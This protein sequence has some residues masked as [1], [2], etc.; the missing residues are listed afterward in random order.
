TTRSENDH[1]RNAP[2]H[3]DEGAAFGSRAERQVKTDEA[4]DRAAP[5]AVPSPARE[6]NDTECGERSTFVA[7]H[8][9]DRVTR[10]KRSIRGRRYRQP[11]RL[12]PKHGNVGG[13]VPTGEG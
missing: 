1:S 4:V 2:L 5:D 6:G 10:A 11:V 8:R 9:Q 13:W 12:E 3:I 7:S